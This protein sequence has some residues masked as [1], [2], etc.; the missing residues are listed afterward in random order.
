VISAIGAST[1]AYAA[2]LGALDAVVADFDA[3]GHAFTEALRRRELGQSFY[4][5][6][7]YQEPRAHTTLRYAAA[8]LEAVDGLDARR[9]A[10]L[11]LGAGQIVIGGQ[12]AAALWT[13]PHEQTQMMNEFLSLGNTVL[14]RSHAEAARL[15]A[16]NVRPRSV[17]PA[18]VEPPVPNVRPRR[19][20]RPGV[21]IWSPH[22]D[23]GYVAW[24]AFALAEF[25]GDVSCV[26]AAGALPK[27]VP[28]RCLGPDDPGLGDVL[29]EAQ[30]VLCADP[31]DPGAAVAFARLGFGVAAPLASGAREYVRDA[32]SFGLETPR[33]V[34]MAVKIAI[35]KPASVRA[36]PQPP[37]APPVPA[38]PLPADELPLVSIMVATYN[39][40]DDLDRCLRDL[41][42]Q[43][44]PRLEIVVNNDAGENV[45]HIV[46]RY[47]RAR[48]VNQPVNLGMLLTIRAEFKNITGEYVQMLADDD[49]LYPD[50]VERLMGAMLR[51]GARVAHGN[52]LIRYQDRDAGGELTTTGFNSI[53][54]SDSTTATEA[55]VSTPI[56][57]Q[58]LIIRRDILDE[59]GEFSIET[60][61][62]DQ[63]FQM[64]A[65]NHYVFV[66]IDQCTSEWR[67]RNLENLSS[68]VDRE[69]ELRKVYEQL[70][71]VPD[72]PWIQEHRRQT[73]AGMAER[74]KD[75]FGPSI[76]IRKPAD[77]ARSHGGPT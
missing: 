29:A 14:V 72:R 77:I 7:L 75:I 64:R 28:G 61:L 62:P 71:P 19:A 42:L 38:L 46:A 11:Q 3:I 53:V 43:T 8:V 20:R 70:Y 57:G 18:L 40:P 9:A 65:A 23:A 56:A 22:T 30:C 45:D 73:L 33:E 58:S 36:T 74:P 63:E 26:V 2:G 4:T 34:E 50:H 24:Y 76:R 17:E 35:G 1:Q 25:F 39:R 52:T 6:M 15:N 49:T 59:I 16:H 69:A 12:P 10:L 54:F 68:K 47:P 27:D 41:S 37:A 21:V 31:D 60:Q 44:Y 32:V 13:L 55:L 5:M 66:W 51:S 48:V 67:V